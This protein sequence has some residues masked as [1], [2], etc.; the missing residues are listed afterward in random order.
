VTL[1]SKRIEQQVQCL[2]PHQRIAI[3]DA[4]SLVNDTVFDAIAV[5]KIVV[6]LYRCFRHDL[7][8]IAVDN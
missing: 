5:G 3:H 2:D 7:A 1:A 4:I 8:A 6:V